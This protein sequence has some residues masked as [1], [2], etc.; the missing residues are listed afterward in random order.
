MVVRADNVELNFAVA[1]GEED[2]RVNADFLSAGAV[3]LFEGR[4]DA[5]L[6]AGTG[7]TVDK[8][9]REVAGVGLSN[10]LQLVALVR[11]GFWML[12]T[13]DFKRSVSL[14]WYYVT[15]HV[16][17]NCYSWIQAGE[18]QRA[19]LLACADDACRPR[20]AALR[21]RFGRTFW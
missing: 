7:R 2:T 1:G 9:V 4:D 6:F 18:D 16:S 11:H 19:N 17:D 3:E 13:S 14:S 10:M 5:G 12:P 15:T 8:E 21:L 20:V